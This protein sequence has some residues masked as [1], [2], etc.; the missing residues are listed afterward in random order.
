MP[1]LVLIDF[2]YGSRPGLNDYWHTPEDTLDKLSADSLRI[3]GEV[4][5]DLLQRVA[6]TRGP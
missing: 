2:E 3:V 1:A 4:T 6:E 5:L